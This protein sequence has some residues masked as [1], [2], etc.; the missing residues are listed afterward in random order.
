MIRQFGN[1]ITE[2]KMKIAA[3]VHVET[4]VV[5]S[6]SSHTEEKICLT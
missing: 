5:Q 3:A 6:R 4:H 2:R 1:L